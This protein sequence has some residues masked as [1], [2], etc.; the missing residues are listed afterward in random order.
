MNDALSDSRDHAAAAWRE[1]PAGKLR[2]GAWLSTN[3]QQ[4]LI[5][6]KRM[7]GLDVNGELEMLLL[8]AEIMNSFLDPAVRSE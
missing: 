2:P 1:S 3:R 5:Q 8:M 7:R 4:S 6:G